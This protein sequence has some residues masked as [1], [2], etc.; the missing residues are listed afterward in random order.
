[1]TWSIVACDPATG[2]LGVAVATHTLAVGARCPFVRAGVGAVATQSITNRDLAPAILDLLA[3][4]AAAGDALAAALGSDGGRD[5][6][7]VHVV[8]RAGRSAAW[9]GRH[10]VEAC[11]DLAGDHLSVAGNM[12]ASNEVLA[13]TLAAFREHSGSDLSERLLLAMAAGEAQGGDR[14]G[15]RSAALLIT[16]DASHPAI[17]LRV[18]GDAAPVRAL[19]ALLTQWRAETAASSQWVLKQTPAGLDDM[20]TLE[21]MWRAQGLALKFRR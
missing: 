12:L 21:A 13:R 2:A 7:Q 11:G 1:M 8:D 20:D 18:D 15:T 10:C 9:T 5:L 17:D 16:S 3:G 6:R 19:Q 14:R 4:G